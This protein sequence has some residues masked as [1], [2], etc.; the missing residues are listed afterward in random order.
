MLLTNYNTLNKV[1][2]QESESEI[3]LVGVEVRHSVQRIE[4]A[5]KHS[6]RGPTVLIPPVGAVRGGGE[7]IEQK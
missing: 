5:G 1:G 6:S 2:N 3:S 4:H 7:V